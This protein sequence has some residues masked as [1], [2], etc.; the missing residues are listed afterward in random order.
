[1]K[2][3]SDTVGN[4]TRDL[5]ACSSVPQPTAPPR[6]SR[7]TVRSQKSEILHPE[8]IVYTTL[9]STDSSAWCESYWVSL[10]TPFMVYLVYSVCVFMVL[11]LHVSEKFCQ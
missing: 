1:M 4:R 3:S 2:N 5:P 10:L 9:F 11:P 6:A 7:R 8:L